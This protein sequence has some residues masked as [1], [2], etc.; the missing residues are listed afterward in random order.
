MYRRE[1]E[2]EPNFTGSRRPQ[3]QPTPPRVHPAPQSWV[4]HSKEEIKMSKNRNQSAPHGAKVGTPPTE[5]GDKKPTEA[6]PRT[7]RD[8]WLGMK[9]RKY[10]REEQRINRM[11]EEEF[12]DF[13]HPIEVEPHSVQELIEE[14]FGAPVSENRLKKLCKMVNAETRIRERGKDTVF[15]LSIQYID[16]LPLNLTNLEAYRLTLEYLT[17]LFSRDKPGKMSQ[18]DNDELLVDCIVDFIK[19]WNVWMDNVSKAERALNKTVKEKKAAGEKANKIA[20]EPREAL[21][22]SG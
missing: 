18:G 14:K 2:E 16:E 15:N 4:S 3:P 17:R 5:A 10:T 9:H 8:A 22:E 12:F 20:S 11:N 21:S 7:V 1:P 13:V 6:A 19:N